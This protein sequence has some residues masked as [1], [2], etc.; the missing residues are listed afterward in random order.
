MFLLVGHFWVLPVRLILSKNGSNGFDLILYFTIWITKRPFVK[1]HVPENKI[2]WL[3]FVSNHFRT[4]EN[5]CSH[6]VEYSISG[7]FSV[8]TGPCILMA[9]KVETGCCLFSIKR[10]PKVG[11]IFRNLVIVGEIFA[12][13]GRK[14]D[15]QDYQ[16]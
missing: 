5:H 15:F 11:N 1:S 13:F 6:V 10:R 9:K 8:A 4:R 16:S 7:S 2:R 14:I 12:T 3:N